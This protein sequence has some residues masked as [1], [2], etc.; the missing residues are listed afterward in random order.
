MKGD[1]RKRNKI[2]MTV[3][4]VVIVLSILAI[5]AI[6]L[7]EFRPKTENP[8]LDP[9]LPSNIGTEDT[10]KENSVNFLVAGLDESE[11]LT[12]VIMVVN[13]DVKA[14]KATILQIPR[15]TFVGTDYNTGGTGKINAIYGHTP[16]G[17]TKISNLATVI[18]EQFQL[19]ID[20]YATITLEGFRNLVDAL[21]GVRMNVPQQIN[22]YEGMV[23]PAGD[24]VLD[25]QKAEWFVL[26]RAGY[27][28]GDLGRVNAQRLFLASFA[29][30]VLDV[31]RIELAGSV[32]PKVYDDITTDLSIKEIIKYMNVV[33]EL[34][35]ENIEVYTLP[36]EGVNHRGQSVY[37]LH[38]EETAKLL[39]EQMRPY[40]EAVPAEALPIIELQN[41]TSYL[42][43]NGENFN[44]VLDPDGASSGK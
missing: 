18:N 31:G 23:I 16:E 19:P 40:A 22:Y 44:N 29:K 11:S 3:S 12:D 28:Q 24:Q 43:E 8:D 36:G 25:G 5:G 33:M 10:I 4:V 38:K 21:G 6:A 34:D 2:I 37:T 35:F 39:N 7:L 42:D 13:F 30:Q 26:F 41:T 14:K 20:H 1:Y 15:D 32:L 17:K 27:V 9:T